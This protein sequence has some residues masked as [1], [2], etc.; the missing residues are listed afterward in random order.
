MNI[1]YA[2]V[3]TQDQNLDLQIRAL[4]EAGC[5][6]IFEDRMSGA[7]SDRPGLAQAIAALEPGTAQRPGSTLTVWKL[8]RLGRGVKGL[9]TLVGELEAK[10]CQFRSLTESIW[11]STPSGRLFFHILAAMGQMERELTVER[12]KAGLNAAKS[13]GVVMG[14]KRKMTPG[15]A[16]SA[17]QLLKSGMPPRDVARNLGV[18][19]P[20][21]YRWLPA[22][23]RS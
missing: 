18:S 9:V 19:V 4:K 22:T 23:S 7:R 16:A 21:L 15:K 2:R 11:T 6:L 8:D 17:L 13:R 1:G 5:D 10:G 20:T 3:S 14:R 12:T